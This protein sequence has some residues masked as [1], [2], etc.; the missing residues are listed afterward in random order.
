MRRE[1]VFTSTVK[2]PLETAYMVAADVEKYPEFMP[3]VVR[4]KVLAR[5]GNQQQVEMVARKALIK[6]TS[7]C[8]VEFD[9]YRTISIEQIDGPFKTMRAQWEFE[10]AKEGTR[11]FFHTEVEFEGS[12]LARIIF[13]ALRRESQH[14]MKAFVRRAE[15]L[16]PIS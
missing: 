14:T 6:E 8:L 7:R 4:I 3:H 5:E 2:A 1:F 16:A 12:L 9:K 15:L 11:V 13:K 10:P